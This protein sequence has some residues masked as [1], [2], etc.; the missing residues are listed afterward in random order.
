MVCQS[1]H[2]LALEVDRNLNLCLDLSETKA[3]ISTPGRVIWS[4]G[5]GRAGIRF[6]K[7][8]GQSLRQLREWLFVNVL[9]AFDHARGTAG[10]PEMIH[11]KALPV[12]SLPLRTL[13]QGLPNGGPR[14]SGRARGS[15]ICS[16]KTRAPSA[17]P[18]A[19]P[20]AIQRE[21]EAGR[22]DRAGA[23][24]MIAEHAHD[25][26]LV[27]RDVR[28]LYLR[29]TEMI[30][31]ASAGSDAPPVG[32]RLQASSGF[33]GECIRTGRRLRCD[34]SETDDRVDRAGC[35]AMGVRSI[36]AVPIRRGSRVED[37]WKC[38]HHSPMHSRPE[39]I[40]VLQQLSG[41]IRR[42]WGAERKLPPATPDIPK[43]IQNASGCPASKYGQ[44]RHSQVEARPIEARPTA[45]RPA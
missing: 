6:Q 14:K 18:S 26:L 5:S 35:R 41:T 32:S 10:S 13:P 29:A 27:P 44:S 23:L 1:R 22:Y 36:V 9:T 2:R 15:G 8:T 31:E 19:I 45:A 4:D 42:S 20:S 38:F 7:L 11:A 3:R 39:D 24:Q 40:S 43:V 34:D 16:R 28:S 33:S 17:V 12:G 21:L 30:C 25:S 37:C